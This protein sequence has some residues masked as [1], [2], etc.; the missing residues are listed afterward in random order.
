MVIVMVMD[1]RKDRT[2]HRVGDNESRWL[3]D[4]SD[5]ACRYR[6]HVLEERVTGFGTY[7][8]LLTAE[9]RQTTGARC[10]SIGP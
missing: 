3:A 4:S 10:L 1:D 5:A 7:Y 2:D 8:C 6:S 9:S